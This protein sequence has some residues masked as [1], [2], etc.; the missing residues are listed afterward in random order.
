MGQILSVPMVLFGA[1]LM[2]FALRRQPAYAA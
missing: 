2:I 1:G